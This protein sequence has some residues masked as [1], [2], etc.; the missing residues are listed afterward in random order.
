MTLIIDKNKKNSNCR[1]LKYA[2]SKHGIDNFKFEIICL[3]F[4]EDMNDLEIE[5]IR[6]FGTLAPNGYN[7]REGGNNGKHHDETKEKIRQSIIALNNKPQLGRPH[8]QEVKDK[9]SASH[10][11]KKMSEQ[12]RQKISETSSKKRPVL[13]FDGNGEIINRFNS[14]IEA[15]AH[16]NVSKSYI[17]RICQGIRKKNEYNLKYEI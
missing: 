10:L 13:Q 4:D 9:I 17:Y 7:L 1:Y 12:A 5:Y 6:K 2:L 16:F 11:G 14:C 8:T 15:A 3:C